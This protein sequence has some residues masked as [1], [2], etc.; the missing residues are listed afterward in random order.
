MPVGVVDVGSNTVRLVVTRDGR[1]VLSKREMLRLGSDVE[2]LGAISDEGL[3]RAARVVAAFAAEARRNNA[4]PLEVL[5]T[6]PGRQALNGQELLER[7]R[8]AAGAS[9]RIL[10]STEEGRLAFLGVVAACSP[11]P[12]RAIAVVDVGGGSAQIV[13]G[14]PRD[15]APWARSIDLGSQRLTS[16]MLPNDPP[17]QEAVERA[18]LEVRSYLEPIEPPPARDAYAVGGTARSLKRIAGGRLD[19]AALDYLLELLAVTPAAQ[20]G[21]RHDIG[22]ERART[23]AAGCVILAETQRLL[24]VPLQVARGGLREGALLELARARAAA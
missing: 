6:S 14:A 9:T 13:V 19:R 16:G 21:E 11:P 1:T 23:L 22:L 20:I 8:S 18:R 24:G 10:T 2:R 15:G 7:L 4:D 5:I 17:G 3:A 12:S